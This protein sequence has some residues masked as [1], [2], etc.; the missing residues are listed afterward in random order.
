MEEIAAHFAVSP[1]LLARENGLTKEPHEGQILQIP[2]QTGNEY[3]VR[4]GDDKELLCGS[5]E[6]YERLNG[7][8][9]FYLGM[10]IRINN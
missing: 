10:R 6:N 7:T 5:A 4:E 9:V 1:F 2:K 8:S 3:T